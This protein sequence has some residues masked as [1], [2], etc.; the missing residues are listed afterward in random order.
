MKAHS[1]SMSLLL[2]IVAMLLIFS[3]CAAVSLKIFANAREMSHKADTL[4]GAAMWAQSAAEVYKSKNG[5]LNEVADVLGGSIDGGKVQLWLSDNWETGGSS[6]LLSL[7]GSS[8]SAVVSVTENE[9]V[10]FELEV[11]TVK[12]G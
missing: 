10:L 12:N 1:K 4:S 5:D 8:D 2:E 7:T 3:L 6:Y 9:D 11:E